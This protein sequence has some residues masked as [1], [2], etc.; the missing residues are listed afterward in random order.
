[1]GGD[2][3]HTCPVCQNENTAKPREPGPL[4]DSFDIALGQ[5]LPHATHLV[6]GVGKPEDGERGDC[7]AALRAF[8]LRVALFDERK[9]SLAGRLDGSEYAVVLALRD[10]VGAGPV[11][12]MKTARGTHYTV[13][14]IPPF[15]FDKLEKRAKGIKRLGVLRMDVDNLG[16]IFQ[17]GL[18]GDATLSRLASLSRVVSLFFEGRVAQICMEVSDLI[19]AV[20]AGGDDLF[21]IGPWDLMPGLARR[22]H[23]E[24]NEL[25]GGNE[26]VHVS[27]GIA[28][29]G[30]KYP[31]Y[32]AADDAK[33]ALERAKDQAGKDAITFL[34]RTCKWEAF[35]EVEEVF[36]KL[37]VLVEAGAPKG[38]LTRLLALDALRE[39]TR[40]RRVKLGLQVMNA[41]PWVW[42]GSYALVRLMQQYG[43][44]E[45]IRQGI[46]NLYEQLTQSGF[47]NLPQVG[48][49]ARW[50]QLRLRDK[51]E[52]ES[53]HQATTD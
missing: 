14:L 35:A 13:N 3:E 30:G 46:A 37:T 45:R 24:L 22:L 6:L 41:G 42:R 39:E 29:I 25:T 20:Y 7:L 43:Q 28:L 4:C 21:L 48:L 17:R 32:Q 50:A 44:E 52:G 47:A 1:M 33:E 38:L 31:V 9:E 8:G 10:S 5:P 15:T 12:D 16:E 34:G 36:R 49:A 11:L 19:Y 51:Q 26:D 2:P 18:G 23:D 53:E 27:A 40:K